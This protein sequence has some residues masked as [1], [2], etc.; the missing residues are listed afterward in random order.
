MERI[1]FADCG[2][3]LLAFF[4]EQQRTHGNVGCLCSGCEVDMV[5][6]L[7]KLSEEGTFS[8]E[9]RSS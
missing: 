5:K 4:R 6:A 8:I 9:K 1:D 7:E 2:R 3:K